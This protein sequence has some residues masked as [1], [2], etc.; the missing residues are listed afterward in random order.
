MLTIFFLSFG[1]YHSTD[2][3]L[4]EIYAIISR[5]RPYPLYTIILSYGQFIYIYLPIGFAP[6]WDKGWVETGSII[7]AKLALQYQIF[8]RLYFQINITKDTPAFVTIIGFVVRQANGI[9]FISQY[10]HITTGIPS[11][12]I[13]HRNGRMLRNNQFFYTG[14]IKMFQPMVHRDA[15]SHTYFTIHKAEIRS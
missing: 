7:Q 12:F 13:V 4:P 11:V 15:F 9:R 5:V 14:R 3:I 2:I 8:N 1:S 6:F 10:I